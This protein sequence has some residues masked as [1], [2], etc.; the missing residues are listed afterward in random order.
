MTFMEKTD[1]GLAHVNIMSSYK[2]PQL[3]FGG[4]KESGS[5]LPEAGT[6]GI[7]FFTEHK[8]CYVKYR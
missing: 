1:V 3:E 7:Q 6:S 5:G 8:V 4:V 2:E